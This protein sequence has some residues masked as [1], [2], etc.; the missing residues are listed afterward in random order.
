MAASAQA[1][2]AH[3]YTT[4]PLNAVLQFAAKVDKWQLAGTAVY[5]FTCRQNANPSAVAVMPAYPTLW[6]QTLKWP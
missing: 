3:Q 1:A 2:L 4:A 5:D 6:L